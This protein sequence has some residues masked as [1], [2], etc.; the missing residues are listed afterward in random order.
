MRGVPSPCSRV[1][2]RPGTSRANAGTHMRL[3]LTSAALLTAFS[4]SQFANAAPPT[5]PRARPS[6]T[7]ASPAPASA[8]SPITYLKCVTTQHGQQINWDLTLN[9][10]AGTIDTYTDVFRRQQREV[11]Q[12][13]SDAVYFDGF[14]L[15]RVDLTLQRQ[16][17]PGDFERGTCQMNEPAARAF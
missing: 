7:R 15:S 3:S 12:F 16:L 10:P 13:T 4:A 8:P 5:H 14:T 1:T 9:E 6:S 2:N 11:A 17:A